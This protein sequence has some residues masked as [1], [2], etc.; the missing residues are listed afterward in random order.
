MY[1]ICTVYSYYDEPDLTKIDFNNFMFH[2][3][4]IY[5][6]NGYFKTINLKQYV[7]T[8]DHI[9]KN[10]SS[11]HVAYSYSK[12][13]LM[14]IELELEIERRIP[15]IDVV[16]MKIVNSKT[17]LP[18][19]ET[20]DTVLEEYGINNVI[21]SRQL[22]SPFLFTLT[23]IN[24]KISLIFD[25]LKYN[26]IRDLPL[27]TTSI[28]SIKQDIYSGSIVQSDNKNIG[29]ISMNKKDNV[30]II[31][32]FLINLV[33]FNTLLGIQLDTICCDILYLDK[34]MFAH[35]VTNNSCSYP[36]G[37][38]KFIFHKDDVIM[39]V[40][41]KEFNKDK[42]LL[43]E[44]NNIYVPFNTYMLT[45]ATLKK[46][47]SVTIYRNKKVKTHNL[48]GI[49]YNDMYPVRLYSSIKVI[50][51]KIYTELNED[52]LIYNCKNGNKIKFAICD[53]YLVD[54]ER[55]IVE[56]D[57]SNNYT[58]KITKKIKI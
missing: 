28:K 33:I 44:I 10:N 37:K 6:G 50:D 21:M 30:V 41:D 57:K 39:K 9:I 23:N 58:F 25:T 38:K 19:L 8:C 29:M 4:M 26:I 42:M 22:V 12:E 5:K 27:L 17:V 16:I 31:P 40:N 11:R 35:I 47:I 56:L 1:S 52:L 14:D 13:L 51:K 3:K 54:N 55:I 53:K 7:I 46:Q 20:V 36:N 32:F 15:E 34:N 18:D 48:S 2:K 45:Y 43:C 49:E 24:D